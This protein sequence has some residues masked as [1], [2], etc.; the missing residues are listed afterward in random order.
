MGMALN[1]IEPF[2]F[3]MMTNE[4]SLAQHYLI[5]AWKWAYADRMAI[6]DPDYVEQA[7][8][9]EA[10]LSKDHA[11]VLRQKFNPKTTFPPRHYADLLDPIEMQILD[12]GTSHMSAVDAQGNVVALTS[13]VNLSFGSKILSPL[14]GVIMNNEMDDFS[15]PNQTNYFGQPP[16]KANYIAAYKK[17]ISSMTPTIVFS[18]G[19]P[20]LAIG[21][22]GGT[23]II[24]GTMQ[25]LLGVIAW[26]ESV[27]QAI[28]NP[29]CH[30]QNTGDTTV[31]AAYPGEFSSFLKSTNHRV[32]QT[33][34]TL[35]SV[36]GIYINPKGGLEAASD[37][38]KKGTPAGY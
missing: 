33:S 8:V 11:A 38:R 32:V 28:G 5:E 17:P 6:G 13:T 35:A 18:N 9:I 19:K 26:G 20:L 37:W 14:T 1:L 21:A 15:S 10:M 23:K 31:E 24:T 22:S 7:H 29:R 30:N 4:S 25:A 34:G 3:P 2:N 27:G 36:Q 16:S 12:S